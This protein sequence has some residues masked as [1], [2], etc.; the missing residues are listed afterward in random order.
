MRELKREE[1]E[2]VMAKLEQVCG[3]STQTLF[4]KQTKLV[5]H[6][7]YIYILHNCLNSLISGLPNRVIE[8]LGA[9]LGKIT[10]SGRFRLE[11]YALHTLAPL[12]QHRVIIKRSAEMN[13][14]YGHNVLKSHIFSLQNDLKA[15]DTC[16][17]FNQD[18]V[19]LGIG[20]F[21]KNYIN[22]ERD[23]GNTMAIILKCDN[24]EYL[25]NESPK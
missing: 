24:G 4:R 23:T 7:D 17:L 6:K 12:A 1:N 9:P 25:R 14:L 15:Q 19:P 5:L 18:E 16:V 22:Y 8:M 10:K 21:V 20:M 13:V 3:N 2:K 11:S